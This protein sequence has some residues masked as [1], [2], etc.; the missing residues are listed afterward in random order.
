MNLDMEKEIALQT[1]DGEIVTTISKKEFDEM[2]KEMSSI[3]IKS[4]LKE[5]DGIKT[6]SRNKKSYSKIWDMFLKVEPEFK[7][8]MG[9]GK[10]E[11]EKIG[12][13][14]FIDFMDWSSKEEVYG[15]RKDRVKAIPCVHCGNHM[16]TFQIDMGL[17][18]HCKPLYRL[19]KLSEVMA[20]EEKNNPGSSAGTIT[21][22][23]YLDAFRKMYFKEAPIEQMVADAFIYDTISGPYTRDLLVERV[24]GV[25]HN[26]EIF[27]V[28]GQQAIETAEAKNLIGNKLESIKAIITSDDSVE[29]K[30]KR[31]TD[32]YK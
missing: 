15:Y 4:E 21:A 17:C 2:N 25:P 32:I 27:S 8:Y 7:A 20:L 6:R 28:I 11:I 10:Q 18:E 16:T 24:I 26:E 13:K 22:F 9:Y 3:S 12:F 1:A 14:R 30:K 23:A 31:I 19:D 29:S 5:E